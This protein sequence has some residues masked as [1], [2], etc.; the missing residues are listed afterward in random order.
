MNRQTP[1]RDLPEVLTPND[2]VEFLPIGRSSVY[3]LLGQGR[4]PA[5]RCGRK[6][7]IAKSAVGAFLGLSD[8]SA[9]SPS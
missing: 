9:P 4:I 7:L 6:L 8:E 1:F 2:L 5:V 3:E